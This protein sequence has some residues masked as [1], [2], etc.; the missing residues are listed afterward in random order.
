MPKATL[1]A[2]RRYTGPIGGSVS[3][4]YADARAIVE[5]LTNVGIDLSDVAKLLEQQGIS[6]FAKSWEE[7]IGSVERGLE[8]AGASIAAYGAVKPASSNGRSSSPPAAAKP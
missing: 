3:N 2:V 8:T 7:L 1:E 4:R 6:T 5:D